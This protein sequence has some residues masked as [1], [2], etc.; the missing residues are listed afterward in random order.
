MEADNDVSTAALTDGGGG[1]RHRFTFLLPSQN[2]DE[3]AT[4]PPPPTSTDDEDD[5]F[6]V[7]DV[8]QILSFLLVNGVISG[9]TALLLQILTVALHFD[10]GGGG[11]GGH[12][13][14]DD[15]DAMM[16]APL[17]SIDDEDDDD[18]SPLLDQV[19]CYLLLNGIISGERALQI[20]QNANM[21][22]DLDLDDGGANMP[23]DLDDGGGFRGVP[24][25]AAAVAGLEKQVFH[26]FDHHGGDDDDDDEAKD[27]AAGCVICME[28]FVAGDE[29]CAIPC[30]G[31]H[32]FHHHCITEWLGRSNVC[33]LCR[34]ALPV[35]EQD[36]GVVA[37]ST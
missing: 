25:S 18:G 27:S 33:P 21:P 1:Q 35:E 6:S 23:L 10:L 20:L 11:G 8:A 4:M 9:E 7:D 34:H 14:N 13:E 22:L 3:D 2:D 31:N 15:E 32:S 26:Q 29:V 16:A 12:G 30:A 28:E 5:D 37:S 19:L 17:P 24:A 36:E